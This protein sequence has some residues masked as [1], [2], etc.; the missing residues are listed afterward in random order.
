VA[1]T[2]YLGDIA[3]FVEPANRLVDRG[4]DVTFL[5]PPGYQK[6][7]GGER[8]RLASYGLDFSASAMHADAEHVR[9][10]R[11]PFAHQI[12]LGRYL[13]RKAWLDDPAAARTS[14]VDACAGAEVVV[15]HPTF[16][17]VAVPA[18]QAAGARVVVGQLFPMMV[19]TGQ[20]LPPV[21][22]RSP[23]LGR[24]VNHIA[25]RAFV[26]G[27]GLVMYDGAM[28]EARRSFGF[29][30]LGGVALRGWM[31]AERTVMLVSRHY[32]A[33]DVSDWPPVIFGGFSPWPG[34][35]GQDRDPAVD[36]FLD[37]GEPPVLVTLGTSSATGAG[38]AF[39][40]IASGLDDFGLRS[41][42]LVGDERNLAAVDGRAGAFT[43]APLGQVLSRCRAAVVSGAL[44]TLAASL[45]AGLPVVVLPQL[46]DQVWHGG[47]VE[48]LGVGVMV[49]RASQV[50][51]AVARIDADPSFRVRAKELSEQMAG[52]DGAAALVDTVESLL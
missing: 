46:F 5:A 31:S 24:T 48:D 49:W 13:M 7:L 30:P 2:A 19:P 40:T 15:A 23:S 17:S 47:R 39:A 14:L 34:P 11:H 21:G 3:P 51:A 27:S 22:K 45:A 41:L 37:A 28:N 38:R 36:A 42:L 50:P 6:V 8:F 32:Y 29:P 52:E 43:F 16:A 20:R 9:L 33:D 25:W 26:R 4:H 12:R 35:A 44:G 10:M 18:A 1:S